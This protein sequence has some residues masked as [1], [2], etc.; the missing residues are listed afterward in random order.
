MKAIVAFALVLF[1]GVAVADPYSMILTQRNSTDTGNL[2][3]I[4]VVPL[5]PSLWYYDPTS[6]FPGYVTLGTGLTISS[7]VLA[8]TSAPVNADWNAVSGLA[9]ILNKPSIP[10]A[11]VN[12]DWASVSGVSQILNKPSLATVATSG[13]FNDL[14]T[15]PTT[16][17]G[18]GITDGAT[19]SALATG[20]ALKLN[21]PAGTTSQYVRGD[22]TLAVLPSTVTK[23]FSYPTRS[24]SVCYQISSTRDSQVSY[25]VNI[26]TSMTLGGTPQGTV[27]LRTYTNSACTT[28]QQT[29][30]SGTSGQPTT[31]SVTVGQQII[32]TAPLAGVIP[33]GLWVQQ[34]PINNSGTN[35]FSPLQGQ[36][37]LL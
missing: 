14:N 29:V 30:V 26:T 25:G 2:T 32:G 7:G 1:A 13:S 31:L 23:S 35:T 34:E 20:L 37:V 16:L 5:A 22:G 6:Q 36:E 19:S 8:L 33:A 9:Q 28:G 3:R 24:L 18:Y 15:K 21:T 11:Q 27:Y 12:S 4:M 10:A 17:S